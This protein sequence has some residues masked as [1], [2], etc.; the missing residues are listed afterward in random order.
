[1]FEQYTCFICGQQFEMSY[2]LL[3]HVDD[4]HPEANQRGEEAAQL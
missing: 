1:M 2:E 3:D 4:C